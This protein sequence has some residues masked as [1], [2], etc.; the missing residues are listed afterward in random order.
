MGLFGVVRKIFKSKPLNK[1]EE[2]ELER[3]R[4]E[5]IKREIER[6][7]PKEPSERY[8]HVDHPNR[9]RMA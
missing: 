8:D 5:K 9:D 6:S 4:N 3:M 7:E 1:G 2:K